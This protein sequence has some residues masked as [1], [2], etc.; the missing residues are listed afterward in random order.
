MYTLRSSVTNCSKLM[1]Q[2]LFLTT[3]NRWHTCRDRGQ[4][5][6]IDVTKKVGFLV[7]VYYVGCLLPN[8]YELPTFL[9]KIWITRN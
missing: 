8:P 4:K 2:L 5:R 7:S 1:I 6:I 3:A 9:L